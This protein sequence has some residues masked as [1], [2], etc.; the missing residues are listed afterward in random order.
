M[1]TGMA[2]V[3]QVR[4][5]VYGLAPAADYSCIVHTTIQMLSLFYNTI[6]I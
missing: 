4:I 5:G 2:C 6:L 3:S 1:I